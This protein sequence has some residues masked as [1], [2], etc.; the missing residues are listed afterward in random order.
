MIARA[1]SE[2]T[3]RSEGKEGGEGFGMGKFM[4]NRG[5]M[6]EGWNGSPR[7]RKTIG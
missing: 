2:D 4:K 6:D 1:A 5:V 7:W 3:E